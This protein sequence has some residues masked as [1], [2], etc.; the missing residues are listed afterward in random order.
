MSGYT[1][2]RTAGVRRR[3]LAWMYVRYKE[4]LGLLFVLLFLSVYASS[5]LITDDSLVAM[6]ML[7]IAAFQLLLVVLYLPARSAREWI[8]R[9]L[10]R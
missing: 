2:T 4:F 5:F 10:N 9:R 6:V 3:F 8:L 7:I 1:N